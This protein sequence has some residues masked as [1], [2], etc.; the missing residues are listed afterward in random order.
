MTDLLDANVWIA[1]GAPDHAHHQR[2]RRYWDHE[3]ADEL[4]L[5][6]VTSLALL[7]LLT[8]E[9]VMGEA[10]LDGASA[11]RA[12]ET[13]RRT[14]GVTVLDEQAS[15]DELLGRWGSDPDLRGAHWT[16]AYLAAFTTAS[17]CRL[18]TF[19]AGFAR[20]PGLSWLHLATDW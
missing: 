11:W 18:V 19:D 20:F 13:W 17:G 1:L 4:A 10:V 2:A 7:R 5:C 3:A 8:N 9:R 6:R 16:D 14:P 15:I 12:V